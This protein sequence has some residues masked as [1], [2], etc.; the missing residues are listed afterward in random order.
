MPRKAAGTHPLAGHRTDPLWV[1]H[2]VHRI[3]GLALA[4][5]LP[6]HF[7][8]LGL[9]LTDAAA[10]DSALGWTD[11]TAVKVAEA[12]LVL[13]LALHLF[14]GLRLLALEFLPWSAR[15][16]TY[17]ALAVGSAFCVSL[18]FFLNAI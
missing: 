2:I 8:V 14:G 16:K 6:L 10:L 5:F 9:A 12:G 4:L 7:Y 18:G 15:Q 17:A 1:A 13:L 3:S 11:Y